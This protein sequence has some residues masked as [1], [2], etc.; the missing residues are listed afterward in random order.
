MQNTP[1]SCFGVHW[2]ASEAECR[3]GN[4]PSY[5]NP[6]NG[7]NR[8]EA[9]K[10]FAS[11]ATTTNNRKA[12]Q[13]TGVIPPQALLQQHRPPPTP[14]R[15]VQAPVVPQ[16]MQQAPIP[17][18][19]PQ[20][21]PQQPMMAHQQV[22]QI[23]Q[24]QF[25][26]PAHAAQPAMVPMNQPMV[27][28]GTQSFLMVPEPSD[29]DVSLGRKMSRTIFRSMFKAGALAFANYMDYYPWGREPPTG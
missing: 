21:Y 27:G 11:C 26:H 19:H 13:Q 25:T 28:A 24:Q 3:G 15:P 18:Q 23:G 9:C 10:W 14:P 6:T 29:T 4:D 1:P 20:Q 16:P 12:Q 8:R 22:T 2:N 17:Q 5:L 7:S